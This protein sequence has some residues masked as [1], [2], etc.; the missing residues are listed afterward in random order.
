MLWKTVF[1]RFTLAQG[2]VVGIFYLAPC[3]GHLGSHELYQ[4]SVYIDVYT[5][6]KY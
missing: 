6:Y 1:S 4:V 3:L 5:I 2:L